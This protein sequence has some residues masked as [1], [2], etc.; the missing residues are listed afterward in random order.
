MSTQPPEDDIVCEAT[1]RPNDARHGLR[2]WVAEAR[3]ARASETEQA[4]EIERLKA[5]NAATLRA[6]NE[7]LVFVDMWSPD[8]GGK[9][10]YRLMPGH[11]PAIARLQD[12]AAQ[13]HPGTALLEDLTRKEA[14]VKALASA[15]ELSG[16]WFEGDW[17]SSGCGWWNVQATPCGEHCTQRR[18][19]LRLA[20]LLK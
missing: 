18:S 13:P 11:G 9:H 16:D 14:Q 1:S 2:V 15:V 20:G 3:R 6:V 7:A 12:V 17:H 10:K 5:D 19:A 8:M 4:A